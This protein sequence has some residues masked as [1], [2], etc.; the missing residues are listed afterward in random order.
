MSLLGVTL[1]AS[2]SDKYLDHIISGYGCLSPEVS[3]ASRPLS[4]VPALAT[5]PAASDPATPPGLLSGH[6]GI[7]SSHRGLLVSAQ[8]LIGVV[9]I[10]GGL[11]IGWGRGNGGRVLRGGGAVLGLVRGPSQRVS[12]S[13]DLVIEAV[14][15]LGSGAV[16]VEPPV[17]DEVVLVEEG[18]VGAE[19]AVLCEA[20]GAVSSADVEGLALSLGVRV[21]TW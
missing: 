4:L 20:T 10:G 6:I 1:S 3:S 19:E 12:L 17:T 8:L 5:S 7:H 14:E 18:S 13:S 11:V 16:K 9:I 15:I 21:V 2:V